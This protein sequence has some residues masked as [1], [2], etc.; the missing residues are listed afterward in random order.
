MSLKLHP[1][2]RWLGHI[3]YHNF[4]YIDL[5]MIKLKRKSCWII[6][7]SADPKLKIQPQTQKT[8]FHETVELKHTEPSS[9]KS[10]LAKLEFSSHNNSRYIRIVSD[11]RIPIITFNIKPSRTPTFFIFFQYWKSWSIARHAC[12]KSHSVKKLLYYRRIFYKGN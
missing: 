10:S 7:N 9:K 5:L 6:W 2:E 4:E 3:T 1:R 8:N 11:L 12:P